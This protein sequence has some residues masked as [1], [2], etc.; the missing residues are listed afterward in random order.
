MWFR[1]STAQT[2]LPCI[3]AELGSTTNEKPCNGDPVSIYA[4]G[5]DEERARL[6]MMTQFMRT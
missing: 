1:P 4:E 6:L 5:P 2:G 3:A